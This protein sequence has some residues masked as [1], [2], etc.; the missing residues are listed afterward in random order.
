MAE[1][2]KYSK[3]EAV[4]VVIF[5]SEG[6][7]TADA[8]E[9]GCRV[10][11]SVPSEATGAVFKE[12]SVEERQDPEKL[13]WVYPESWTGAFGDAAKVGAEEGFFW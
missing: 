12:V 7:N 9:L 1:D 5:A 6:D 10:L 3:R 2:D 4:A 13:P 8:R 11:N